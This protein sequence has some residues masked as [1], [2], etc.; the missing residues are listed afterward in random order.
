MQ[1][2]EQNA[3]LFNLKISK[4]LSSLRCNIDTTSIHQYLCL[5]PFLFNSTPKSI[6]R[7]LRRAIRNLH[8]LKVK[9]TDSGSE[10]KQKD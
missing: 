5:I 1:K 6:F 8:E 3:K 7:I 10:E 4:H 2:Y 9:A